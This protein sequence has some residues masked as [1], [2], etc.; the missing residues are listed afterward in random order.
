MGVKIRIEPFVVVH[1]FNPNTREAEAVVYL[2][3]RP[4][5]STRTAR[6]TQRNL[7]SKEKKKKKSCIF[8]SR[9]LIYLMFYLIFSRINNNF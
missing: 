3:S 5:W 4:A 2:S 1:T 8:V 9:T 7:V 6:A